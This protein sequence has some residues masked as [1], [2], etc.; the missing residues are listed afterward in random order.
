MKHKRPRPM[1]LAGAAAPGGP[2]DRLRGDG[3]KQTFTGVG[4]RPGK[5]KAAGAP[6]RLRGRKEVLLL[7]RPASEGSAG[8]PGS[9]PASRSP[10]GPGSRQRPWRSG[11]IP[12]GQ[13]SARQ[14]GDAE[15]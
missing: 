6:D 3:P 4:A 11:R 13:T 10:A 2:G 14:E 5:G 1:S 8:G 12:A 15:V 7:L 9:G